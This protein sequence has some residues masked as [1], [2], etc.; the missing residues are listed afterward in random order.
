MTLNH[1]RLELGSQR[2]SLARLNRKIDEAEDALAK[3]VAESRSSINLMR[4]ERLTLEAK[5]FQTMAYIAPIRRLPN[6]LLRHIFLCNFDDFPCSAWVL[7][8]VSSLWRR[9][10]LSMPKLWSKV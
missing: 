8:A 7:A 3:I 6:E 9:L 10:A 1:A 4:K 2:G 5:V